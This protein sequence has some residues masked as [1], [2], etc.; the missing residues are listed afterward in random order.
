MRGADRMRID[1]HRPSVLTPARTVT[2]TSVGGCLVVAAAR[3]VTGGAGPAPM[4][5]ALSPLALPIAAAT[6]VA[7]AALRQPVVA[8]LAACAVAANVPWPVESEPRESEPRESEPRDDRATA[9]TVLALNLRHGSADA[10]Q[11][12]D[13]LYRAQPD[14]VAFA[15]LTR[16]AVDRL[17]RAG[18]DDLWPHTT[19]EPS[20][21][22]DS[23]TGVYSRLPVRVCPPLRETT[24]AMAT[25]EVTV[26]GRVVRIVAVHAF[27]P[28]PGRTA[29]WRA[30]LRSLRDQATAR[31]TPLILLGDF[32]ASVDH[33]AFRSVLATG[34]RDA[35]RAAGRTRVSTWPTGSVLPALLHLDHVLVSPELAVT[36]VSEHAVAGTDHRAV[37]AELRLHR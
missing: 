36:G 5:A 30:D 10:G 28:L 31:A 18:L 15:E 22:G 16:G 1:D 8:T 9:L 2:A 6:A 19:V 32:N 3:L 26:G 24:M 20:R 11:V 29:A 25:V 34:M 17:R 13:L 7:A 12:M 14:I 27:P 37:V 23:G 35:H 21:Q 4:I 33:H